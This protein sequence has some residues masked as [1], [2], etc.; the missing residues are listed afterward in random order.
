MECPNPHCKGQL[1]LTRMISSTLGVT[2]E[3]PE[4]DIK[5]CEDYIVCAECGE[6]PPYTWEGE[7]IVLAGEESDG[8]H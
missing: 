1:I 3:V 6:P 8:G 4:V 2:G 5:E 7:K